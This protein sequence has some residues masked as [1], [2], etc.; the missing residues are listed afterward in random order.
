MVRRAAPAWRHAV[1][2]NHD[3]PVPEMTLRA[4]GATLDA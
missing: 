3:R 4:G 1:R 2:M